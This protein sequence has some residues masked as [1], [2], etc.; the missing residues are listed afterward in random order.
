MFHPTCPY[1]RS[2]ET[3]RHGGKRWKCKRRFCGHTFTSRR[4]RDLRDRAAIAGYL[5]DRSPYARLGVRWK[6]DRSTAYRRVRRALARCRPLLVRTKRLLSDCDG[7]CLLDAKHLRIRG[8]R[9]TLFV[10]WDRGLGLPLHFLLREE[11]EKELWYWRLLVDLERLGYKP[12]AFVSDGINVLEE[13]LVERYPDLPH[14][15]CTVH[16]FMRAKALVAPG[17]VRSER[18][19]EFLGL[20]RTILWSSTL[21]VA[22]KRTRRLWSTEGLTAKERRTLQWI[23]SVLPRCFVAVDPRWR[24]LHLPRSSNAIENVMGQVEGRLKTQRGIKSSVVLDALINV[25]LAHVS[26]QTITHT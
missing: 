26:K 14:Q 10:A 17:R 23:W 25:I 11:G 21:V 19:R 16:V 2:V 15:R 3:I 9:F 24:G 18:A 7:V 5:F 22:R 20:I 8:V 1:C 12:K 6:V 13:F 4:K